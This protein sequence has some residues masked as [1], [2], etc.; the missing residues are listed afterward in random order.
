MNTTTT[1]INLPNRP[2]S[3]LDLVMYAKLMKI[4]HFRGVYMRDSLPKKI[5]PRERGIINLDNCNGS[6]T[7]WTAYKKNGKAIVYFDSFGNLRPPMEVM[8]YFESNG[9]VK[10]V[11][12]YNIY[13]NYNTYNCGHLCLTF[14]NK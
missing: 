8:Q 6:G 1:P 9:S 4:P 14:L 10:V 5:C 12:N 3:N 7:H 13:Q 11:F 2:L